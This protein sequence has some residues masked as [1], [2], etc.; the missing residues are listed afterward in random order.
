MSGGGDRGSAS[1]S[2]F[3]R[4]FPILLKLLLRNQLGILF[5]S[6]SF[7]LALPVANSCEAGSS[8]GT[9]TV[10]K[11]PGGSDCAS[12]ALECAVGRAGRNMPFL[13]GEIASAIAAEPIADTWGVDD[14]DPKLILKSCDGVFRG[15]LGAGA[16]VG[17]G[18]PCGDSGET[19]G[20]DEGS[21]GADASRGA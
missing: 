3:G 2:E 6:F 10:G 15:D 9:G 7:A 17:T 16:G 18:G 19:G 5:S 4:N 12:A 1:A 20:G 11:T 8:L 21:E 14:E 13:F